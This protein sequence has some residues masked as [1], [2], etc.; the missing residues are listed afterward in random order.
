M[1][2]GMFTKTENKKMFWKEY[3]KQCVDI[4]FGSLPIVV[5]ISFFL[6]AVITVQT[7]A[8]FVNPLI[9]I[10]TIGIVVRD[11]MLLEFAPSF[12]SIVLAGVVGSK[13]ASELGNM[14]I[15]EQI[16][17]L[18]IMGINTKNYLIL[19]K[20]LASF[21][22]VPILVGISAVIGIWGGYFVGGL[23]GAVAPEVFVMGIRKVFDPNYVS[24]AFYKSFIFSFIISTIPCYFGYYVNGGALEIGKAGTR[25]VVVSCILILIADYLVAAIAI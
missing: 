2:K 13:I 19:P 17:A 21:T 8:Q 10:T 15:S 6:G 12:L 23:T 3:I 24:I 5:I 18:E 22:M 7:S 4:G 16:D 1:L 20:I 11:G 14:R 25:A 9:P